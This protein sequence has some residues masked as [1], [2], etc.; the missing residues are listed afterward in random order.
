MNTLVFAENNTKP[1]ENKEDKFSP[2]NKE[3][4]KEQV[5]ETMHTI[6][7]NGTD[8]SYKATAGTI[9]LQDDQSNKKASLFYI[10]YTKNDVQD[11]TKRPIT[12][13]F[14]GG[15]GS[16]SVWLHM[17]LLGPKRVAMNEEGDAAPPYHYVSNEY[18]LLDQTDLVFID[19]ISTGYSRTVPGE[20]PKQYHGVD[21][22]IKS[23]GEFIRLYVTRENRWLSPKFLCG[24]SYGTTRAAGLAGHLQE[25]FHMDL[26]GIVLVSTVLNFQTL[27][28]MESGNELPYVLYLPS[29]AATAW[30]HKK[31]PADLMAKDLPEIVEEAEQFA[32]NEYLLA[33]MKGNL[34]SPEEKN[35]IAQ[36]LAYYT[37]LTPSYIERANLRVNA[38]RFEKEL[39]RD[40]NRVVG[41]FDSRFQGV[42]LDA[43]ADS[44]DFDPSTAGVFGSYTASFNA[45][46]RGDLKWEKDDEYKILANVWPW[47]FG[48]SSN[49]YLNVSDTLREVLTRNP[50]VKVFVANGYYDLATPYF[51]T[52]YTFN[53]IPL[54]PVLGQPI[55]MK[56]YGAGHMMYIHYPSLVQMRTDL[57]E[58][59]QNTLK[60]AHNTWN[61]LVR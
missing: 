57:V 19:P 56:Y 26:N 5:S 39:M 18:S 4:L 22:D 21:E 51:A 6:K 52:E 48:K 24:E 1:P 14:N 50:S 20:D 3:P 11:V 15:P 47:N 55:T 46:V 32:T 30:Y 35:K 45:Y 37:G 40:Q 27:D 17:G 10:A 54:D 23:V 12:F 2:A 8:I 34:L 43:C 42:D 38:M 33:L 41:R 58:F 60:N 36:K 59:Y 13:C 9:L 31:L 28:K 29:F 61:R 44:Y 53:H 49:K 25:E 16:S 7:I